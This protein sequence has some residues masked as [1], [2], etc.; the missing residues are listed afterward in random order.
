MKQHSLEE[1]RA[2]I[3]AGS[4]V[5]ERNFDRGDAGGLVRDYYVEQ[6]LMSAPDATL[7]RGREAI[8]GLFEAVMKSFRTCRLEQVE[9]R[10]DGTLAYELG[11]AILSPREGGANA[12]CRYMIAWRQGSAGWRVESDFFAWGII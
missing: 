11:R 3:R 9:V 6:P 8:T 2:A 10:A 5:F 1:I 7:L 12:E 4:D